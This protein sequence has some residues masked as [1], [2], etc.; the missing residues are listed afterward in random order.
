MSQKTNHPAL[1]WTGHVANLLTLGSVV[2]IVAAVLALTPWL[3]SRETPLW[4]LGLLLGAALV[5]GLTAVW[6]WAR[7]SRNA[8]TGLLILVCGLAGLVHFA[9]IYATQLRQSAASLIPQLMPGFWIALAA[10]LGLIVQVVFKRAVK[11][12]DSGDRTAGASRVTTPG[13]TA[14]SDPAPQ[15]PPASIANGLSKS[16][17]H[18]V[19]KRGGVTLGQ[20]IAVAVDALWANKLRSSLTMLGIVIGVMAVVA[21][22]SVGQGATADIT[23][24]IEGIGTNL[25]SISAAR[26]F[27]R[28]SLTLE[29]A[30]AIKDSV[31][32]LSGVAPQMSTSATVV[33]GDLNYTATVLGT[34]PDYAV[35]RNLTLDEGRFFDD[36]EYDDRSR[37]VVLGSG[38][39]EEIF[40]YTDP[41]GNE[42][43]IGA[44]TYEVVGVLAEQDTGFGGNANDQVYLPLT[45]GYRLLFTGR[46]VTGTDYQVSS[47]QISAED[48]DQ[49]SFVVSEITDLLRARHDLDLEDDDDFMITNQQDLLESLSAVSG[50]LTVLLA[51][52]ASV[53]LLVGGI[54]IMN[55]SLVSVTERTKE[56]GL[57]K[58][59]AGRRRQILQQFLIET[60]AL[61]TLGGVIGVLA[62]V[63]V[64]VLVNNSGTLSAK[65]APESILLGLGFSVAVGLFFGVYPANRAASLQPI[66]ALRYE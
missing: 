21:L 44:R 28:T 31:S 13:R 17:H 20:N 47:I 24:Q 7:P 4:A 58:A 10:T 22:V 41:V 52:I 32:G 51:A 43:R 39:V 27:G 64:A 62:G 1:R 26:G 42:V 12:S 33:A 60:V 50:T 65:V 48:P 34:T 8:N 29:D 36:A 19:R 18:P 54:G 38:V 3:T 63:G 59:L 45:T 25:I 23:S 16:A 53:S 57:R 55:I 15:T 35:V 14:K 5:A 40:P 11:G 9:Y 49:V 66:E 46:G 56:I 37:V 61:S 2:V 30:E 6:S